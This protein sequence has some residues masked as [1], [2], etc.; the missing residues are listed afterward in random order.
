MDDSGFILDPAHPFHNFDQGYPEFSPV[1]CSPLCLIMAPIFNLQN[2]PNWKAECTYIVRLQ[3][4]VV[5]LCTHS[6]S[7]SFPPSLHDNSLHFLIPEQSDAKILPERID[8]CFQ[9]QD[10]FRFL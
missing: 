1:V 10:N 6:R 9:I 2:A 7:F 4:S 8:A 3:L 5:E